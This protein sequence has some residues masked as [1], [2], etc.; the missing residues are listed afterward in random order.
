MI[1]ETDYN[2]IEIGQFGKTIPHNI[3]Q[4]V[5]TIFS[6]IIFNRETEIEKIL[7]NGWLLFNYSDINTLNRRYKIKITKQPNQNPGVFLFKFLHKINYNNRNVDLTDILPFSQF[8]NYF[9][10]NYKEIMG[11]EFDYRKFEHYRVREN[12]DVWELYIINISDVEINYST[13]KKHKKPTDNKQTTTIDNE[14]LKLKFQILQQQFKKFQLF[15]QCGSKNKIIK[16]ISKITDDVPENIDKNID[17]NNSYIL[18]ISPSEKH[19]EKSINKIVNEIKLK[20]NI[21]QDTN[22]IFLGKIV[23]KKRKKELSVFAIK[24]T[25]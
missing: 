4:D 2:E 16:T 19:I 14:N 24:C 17:D 5:N 1:S 21:V 20:T 7:Y 22:N 10:K 12:G 8:I 23:D 3:V 25:V 13:F 9:N 15:L 6:P 11:F 18:L